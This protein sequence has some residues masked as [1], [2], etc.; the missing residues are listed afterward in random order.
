MKITKSQ[1]EYVLNAIQTIGRLLPSR[2]SSAFQ[3]GL[4][5]RI[6]LEQEYRHGPQ[7]VL[8]FTCAT[9]GDCPLSLSLMVP[10]E[11]VNCSPKMYK[12]KEI[13]KRASVVSEL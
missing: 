5:T 13:I 6:F 10:Q 3:S 9:E 1:P 7:I 11:Q 2:C 8:R 12:S 4:K